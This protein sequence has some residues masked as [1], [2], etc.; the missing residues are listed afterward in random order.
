MAKPL[1][2]SVLNKRKNLDSVTC[3]QIPTEEHMDNNVTSKPKTING[4]KVIDKHVIL[5]PSQFTI[6]ESQF[7][8]FGDKLGYSEVET[9]VCESITD[10]LI[11]H[12]VTI[13]SMQ[14]G[15]DKTGS[16]SDVM[17][18][19]LKEINKLHKQFINDNKGEIFSIDGKYFWV[20]A[21]N[22][23]REFSATF[24]ARTPDGYTATTYQEHLIKKANA[25]GLN[26]DNEVKDVIEEEKTEVNNE[27]I[28]EL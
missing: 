18:T 3:S 1:N 24:T 25:L 6:L 4:Y 21:K 14:V 19:F 5:T 16:N 27:V 28:N 10:A 13:T 22:K 2:I 17:N 9:F 12:N 7:N 20:D 23:M 11:S 8:K 15:S 26:L